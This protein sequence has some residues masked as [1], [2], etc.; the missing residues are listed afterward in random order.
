MQT[1][2][3]IHQQSLQMLKINAITFSIGQRIMYVL[4]YKKG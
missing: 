2:I 1:L 3:L 4:L